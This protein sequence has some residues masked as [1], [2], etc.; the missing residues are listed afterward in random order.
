[1]SAIP[2]LLN[3]LHAHDS[4]RVVLGALLMDGM[5]GMEHCLR[6]SPEMF[7]LPAHQILFR[8][9]TRLSGDG[10]DWNP[11]SIGE[12]L[13]ERNLYENVTGN[14]GATYLQALTDSTP[15]QRYNPSEHVR[16]IVDSWKRRRGA[17]LCEAFGKELKE[18]EDA[19]A[20]LACL[21]ASVFDVIGKLKSRKTRSSSTT[22]YA[23]MKH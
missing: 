10:L 7:Y 21:Q 6:L 19:D 14:V 1:M 5:T 23:P 12:V 8:E 22:Q 11:V 2:S 15:Y 3:G 13:R 20:T 18:G 9:M 4:E 17:E 16:R